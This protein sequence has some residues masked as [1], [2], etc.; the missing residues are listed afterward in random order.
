MSNVKGLLDKIE[1][2]GQALF[3]ESEY[4]CMGDTSSLCRLQSVEEKL[5]QKLH[6]VFGNH[7]FVAV[8]YGSSALSN[9]AILSDVDLMIFTHGAEA[10]KFQRIVLLFRSIMEEGIPIDTEVPLHRKLMVKFELATKAVEAGPPLDKWDA[11]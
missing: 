2:L 7:D 4:A 11:Y 1:Q 5:S 10:S 9:N 3:I 8:L 6:G